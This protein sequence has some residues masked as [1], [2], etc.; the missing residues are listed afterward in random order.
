MADGNPFSS[1]T[2]TNPY[3][4]FLTAFNNPP[5]SQGGQQS[6]QGQGNIAQIV[7]ALLA[8]RAQK[9]PG[10]VTAPGTYEGNIPTQANPYS[11]SGQYGMPGDGQSA[12]P[13]ADPAT[14]ALFA[15]PP[16]S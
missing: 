2:P 8:Q 10:V 3:I 9:S 6:G 1:G 12:V 15:Q 4:A 11:G 5:G 16:S 13:Y 14:Q 7:Q